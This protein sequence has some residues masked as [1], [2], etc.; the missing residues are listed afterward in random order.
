MPDL[1]GFY[2]LHENGTLIFKR[3]DEGRVED[4]SKSDF[5]KC[6]WPLDN[7]KRADCWHIIIEAS[8]AGVNAERIRVLQE[9]WGCDE[10]DANVFAAYVGVSLVQCEDDGWLATVP[11]AFHRIRGSGKGA[12]E[13][14]VSLCRGL[15]WKASKRRVSFEELVR[16]A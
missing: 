1:A 6:Y 12:T 4:F 10:R 9:L 15:G 11:D 5:V 8:V 13:A 14:L 7:G 16:A 2:Y 3:W